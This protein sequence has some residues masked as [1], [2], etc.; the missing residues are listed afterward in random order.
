[1]RSGA[2]AAAWQPV[3]QP[4]RYPFTAYPTGWF[5][6]CWGAWLGPGEV[7]AERA[8]GQELVAF[9][10]LDGTL[11]VLDAHCPHL[12][13]HLGEGGR[14]DG[15]A[16]ACPFHGWRFDTDGRCVEVPFQDGPTAAGVRSWPVREVDGMILIWHD[17]AGAPPA[18]EVPPMATDG[19]HPL[20]LPD[21]CTWVVATHC[22]EIVE[23]GADTAHFPEVH[24][25]LEPGP[26]PEPQL[27]GPRARIVVRSTTDASTT[28]GTYRTSIDVTAHGL[29]IQH[30][31]SEVDG[32]GVRNRVL[33]HAT[34]LDERHVRVLAPISVGTTGDD[35]GD[36]FV[37]DAWH[38]S[39]VE[40]FERDARI[41]EN[42]VYRSV[43][44]LSRVDGPIMELR[45]WAA[46]FYPTEG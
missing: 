36:S 40:N 21:D 4:Y 12:G 19:W 41:W 34:P 29:G 9:R 33:I 24:G 31:A 2:E 20:E 13:A 39:F 42:K 28:G 1:M 27:D 7:R 17:A 18:W 25:T 44:R 43:P 37:H 11:A 32:V 23:N 46:Q 15:G 14:V 22:Q 6:L 10:T 5:G 38:A 26:R 3:Q 35:A 45:R 30:V 8:F 16:V